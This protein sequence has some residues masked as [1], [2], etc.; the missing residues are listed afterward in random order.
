MSGLGFG[1]SWSM[2]EDFAVNRIRFLVFCSDTVLCQPVPP[3]EAMRVG[4]C[5]G[6]GG[7]LCGWVCELVMYSFLR[8]CVG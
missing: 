6:S 3:I 4:A 8:V 2:G 5:I 1:N 7:K